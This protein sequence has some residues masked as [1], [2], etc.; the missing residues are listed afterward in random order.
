MKM[1][2][3]T[4]F[5]KRN[6]FYLAMGIVVIGAFAAVLFLPNEGN[7]KPDTNVQN[8]QVDSSVTDEYEDEVITVDDT[9]GDENSIQDPT[10]SEDIELSDGQVADEVAN[11]DEDGESTQLAPTVTD[12]ASNKATEEAGTTEVEEEASTETFESTTVDSLEEPFFADG[13]T[14]GLPVEGDIVVP[15]TDDNTKHWFSKSL[16][17]TMRTYGICLSASEGEEVKAVAQGTVV[18]ILSDST[19]LEDDNMP[20]VGSVMIIDLGNGYKV[21]YGFQN[22]TPDMALKGQVVNVG[23]VLGTVG[24]PTGAFISEGDN[25]YLQVTHNDK[26]VSPETFFQLAKA[27]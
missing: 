11:T 25:I 3:I 1:N 21:T 27:E 18:D 26:I 17:Q 22:G 12:E 10:V 20:Y 13:D 8:E 4:Q 6:V 23:D 2:K 16:N 14:F 5:L 7:V 24:A 15:Y 9:A 19:T